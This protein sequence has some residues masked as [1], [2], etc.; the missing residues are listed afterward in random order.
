METLAS[1]VT[2]PPPADAASTAQPDPD[3]ADAKLGDG[4]GEG[5][6][7]SAPDAR[8][9]EKTPD[10]DK[11]QERIDKLTREK[12][13]AL[14]EADLNRYQ[15]ERMREQMAQFEREDKADEAKNSGPPTLESCGYDEAKFHAANH[16]YYSNLAKETSVKTT[17]EAIK[18]AR[19]A[20]RNTERQQ[21]W[22]AKEAEF[23]K[24]KPD[25][26]EKAYDRSLPLTDTIIAAAAESS[27]GPAVIYHLAENRDKFDVIRQLPPMA[28]ALEIGRIVERL[29]K[30]VVVPPVSQ[31]PPPPPKVESQ[32]AATDKSPEDMI[33]ATPTQFAKWRGKYMKK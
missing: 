27:M 2:A 20:D 15:A 5:S 8:A 11:T 24:S 18:A 26:F 32:A 3:K 9:P 30:P 23:A 7:P 29:A 17:E 31:A 14:R 16:A 6:A 10:R 21:S 4:E 13:D 25:Y 22:K 28:Q 12:Y 1:G 33:G 19:E